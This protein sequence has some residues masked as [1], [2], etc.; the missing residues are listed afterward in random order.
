MR[1]S[2]APLQTCDLHHQSCLTS[3]ALFYPLNPPKVPLMDD[4]WQS[5]WLLITSFSLS[6]FI[7]MA[8]TSKTKKSATPQTP[9]KGSKKIWWK[10]Q[11]PPEHPPLETEASNADK[12]EEPSLRRMMSFHMD[13]SSRLSVTEQRVETGCPERCAEPS[14]CRC[15]TQYQ[16]TGCHGWSEAST[17]AWPADHKALHGVKDHV[18]ALV[19]SYLRGAPTMILST[20]DE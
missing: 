19:G 20:T 14:S 6:L 4:F 16:Q 13:I 8:P 11:P 9:R 10:A 15:C 3:M 18:R 12:D 5:R 1:V 17:T 2:T 7:T